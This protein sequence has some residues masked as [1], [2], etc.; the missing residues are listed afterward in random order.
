[1]KRASNMRRAMVGGLI[2]LGIT[3]GAVTASLGDSAPPG[4]GVGSPSEPFAVVVPQ[5]P[6]LT[7][8]RVVGIARSEAQAAGEAS[9]S[10]RS[11]EGTLQEA[12]RTID[13]S[14]STPTPSD[15]GLLS[16][17][18]R[19]VYLVQMTGHFTVD[20]VPV[21]RGSGAPTGS[22]YDLVIDSHTGEVVGRALPRQPASGLASTAS[23]RGRI[24][25]S[26][27][28]PTGSVLV[29]F[30]GK[31]VVVAYVGKVIFHRS[32][33]G[34]RQFV[35]HFPPGT[36][37]L[38]VKESSGHYCPGRRVVIRAYQETRLTLKGCNR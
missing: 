21:P 16:Q 17:F 18:L 11:G 22:I 1:M 34:V 15:P 35:F 38:A 31:G 10:I 29:R 19:P 23:L 7:T 3:S 37:E 6:K 26:V 20:N 30:D 32:K 25:L 14:E 2:G 5:G 36:Y 24:A 13:P 27:P 28:P 4:A 33:P 8:E 12:K 9:P